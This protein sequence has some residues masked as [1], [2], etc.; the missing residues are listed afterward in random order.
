[1]V[2]SDSS[3][4]TYSI[5]REQLE[6]GKFITVS[7]GTSSMIPLIHPGDSVSVAP[8]SSGGLHPGDIV[9][10]DS[11]EGFIVHRLLGLEETEGKLHAL[12][13]GDHIRRFDEPV[14]ADRIIGKV[15]KIFR[16][17]GEVDLSSSVSRFRQR[18][19]ALYFLGQGR[20]LNAAR[21][22]KA[23]LQQGGR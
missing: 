17:E 9:L 5:L 8:V 2:P 12:T 11:G 23:L 7:V 14:P 18:V 22:V 1:M 15:L 3:N 6:Q 19:G 20:L 16:S 13:R 21:K 10:I 4:T